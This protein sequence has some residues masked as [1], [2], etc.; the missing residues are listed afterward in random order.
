MVLFSL[1][2]SHTIGFECT[3]MTQL[4]DISFTKYLIADLQYIIY[5]TSQMGTLD[6][7]ECLFYL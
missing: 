5:L 6:P 2:S 7:T 1:A 4:V 3:K